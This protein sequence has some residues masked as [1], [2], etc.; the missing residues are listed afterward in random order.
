M[1]GVLYRL[2]S[3]D[4]VARLVLQKKTC[5]QVY[6]REVHACEMHVYEVHGCEMHAREVHAHE[7]SIPCL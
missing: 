4:G 5:M 2:S 7:D 6:A 3:E 1:P